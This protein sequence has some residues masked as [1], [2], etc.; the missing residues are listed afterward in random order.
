MREQLVYTFRKFI[1]LDEILD[2]LVGGYAIILSLL[3]GLF[4]IYSFYS[5]RI[6]NQ[7]ADVANLLGFMQLCMQ[8]EAEASSLSQDKP[9]PS[10]TCQNDQDISRLCSKSRPAAIQAL[11]KYVD[12]GFAWPEPSTDID[13]WLS[14]QERTEFYVVVFCFTVVIGLVIAYRLAKSIRQRMRRDDEQNEASPSMVGGSGAARDALPSGD[15]TV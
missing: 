13:S 5:S 9:E 12:T 15:G 8:Q 11:A 14:S 4:T 1:F 10:L 2:A 6:A 3:F 7:Q